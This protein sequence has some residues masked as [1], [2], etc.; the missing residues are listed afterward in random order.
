MT[1]P[2]TQGET[3]FRKHDLPGTGFPSTRTW[4]PTTLEHLIEICSTHSAGVRLKAGG[5]HWALGGATLSDGEFIETHD[6]R[7]LMAGMGKTLFD[8]V[9]DRMTDEFL[10]AM[11]N[12]HPPS[13]EA[14]EHG[15]D[16]TYLVHIETGKRVYQLYAELDDDANEND[17]GLARRLLTDY[18]NPWYAGPWA[19]RTLGG[20]GGQTV[21]GA[22]TTGTHGGD[23]RGAPIADDVAAIHL[24]ADGGKHYWIEPRHQPEEAPLADEA[25]L[26]DFY[27]A[28][29]YGGLDSFEVIHDDQLFNAV[30]ISAGRFGIVY[31]IVLRAVRQYMLH[32]NRVLA[33]WQDIREDIT[34]FGS[35]L[36]ELPND[37]PKDMT[38]SRFLQIVVC[39]TPF[40]NFQKNLAAITRRWNVALD[41]NQLPP[42]GRT[43]RVGNRS[44]ANDPL[45]G[46]PSYEFAGKSFAY[47]PDKDDK[48]KAAEPGFLEKACANGDFME[49][50]VQE[51]CDEIEKFLKDNTVEVGGAMAAATALGL[52]P[53]LLAL[54]APLAIILL[55]LLAW[56]AKMRAEGGGQRLGQVLDEVRSTVLDRDDPAEKAAGMLVWQMIAYKAFDSSAGSARLHGD[57]LR[58]HGSPRLQQPELRR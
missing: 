30:L 36:Y 52:A 21:F 25:K 35:S 57:Q 37:A 40:F 17:R 39:L 19:F 9:P 3:W 20:A 48:N 56:L 1:V 11:A 2:S 51:V 55:L 41:P 12:R 32:E 58:R 28:A 27:G 46:E 54:A 29:K 7:N 23:F 22:L 34:K 42:N 13:F 8:V 4:F 33:T 15:D 14:N 10:R 18:N 49:G 5:S 50:V 45:T 38:L 31:S 47:A 53:G 26:R 44:P 6:P 43:E 24:V 16:T